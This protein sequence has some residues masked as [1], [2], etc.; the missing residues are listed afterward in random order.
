MGLGADP[1]GDHE[2][3]GVVVTRPQPDHAGFDV[4]PG[5]GLANRRGA[6]CPFP[7]A[8]GNRSN[9]PHQETFCSSLPS[10]RGLS[11]G[12][13]R[14]STR[15]ATG[16]H[17]NS[18]GLGRLPADWLIRSPDYDWKTAGDTPKHLDVNPCIHDELKI[19][20]K[21]PRHSSGLRVGSELGSDLGTLGVV[22][23]RVGARTRD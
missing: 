21:S 13:S 17:R 6:L 19:S 14:V 3:A 23:R 5:K 10:V 11:T 7:R 18:R 22:L 1:D 4:E 20:A 8:W 12:P 2:V 16:A 9:V 15:Q